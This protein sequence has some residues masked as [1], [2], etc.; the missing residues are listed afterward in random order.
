MKRECLISSLC[1]FNLIYAK[2]LKYFSNFKPGPLQVG[3]ESVV[4]DYVTLTNDLGSNLPNEF[5]VCT[6]LFVDIVTTT[7]SIFQLMKKDGT[8][9]F[10][11]YYDT[12]P[13]SS[14]GEDLFYCIQAGKYLL[15][16]HIREAL[17]TS[18]ALTISTVSINCLV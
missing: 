6:S 17:N 15:C 2:D 1:L 13:L 12:R 16:I 11:I 14:T 9:W 7:Q 8:A 18:Q 3:R 5:T 4:T 10:F